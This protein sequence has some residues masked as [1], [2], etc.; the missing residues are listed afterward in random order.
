MAVATGDP[1]APAPAGGAAR[2]GVRCRRVEAGEIAALAD[3]L[4]EGF[5]ARG[6]GAWRDALARLAAWTA[7]QN[8]PGFGYVLAD[9][10]GLVGCLL[11]LYGAGGTRCSLSSW[12]VAQSHRR[13]GTMLVSAALR[14]RTITYL[15]ISSEHHTRP[16]IEAQGF[17]RYTGGVV[18][19][20][21][22]AA[23]RGLRTAVSWARPGPAYAVDP[24][25]AALVA[26]HAGFGCLTFWCLSGGRAHPFVVA[27]RRV[28]N[29]LS[30]GQVVY[31]GPET[32]WRV[33]AHAVGRALA[34]HGLFVLLLDASGPVPGLPGRFLPG[35]MPKYA[36]GPAPPPCGDLAYTEAAL[37]GT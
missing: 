13:F 4:A 18:A 19:A 20:L 29:R 36:R 10:D 26:H 30:I 5:P 31:C 3:L 9:G 33:V 16:I 25:E 32:D 14:D 7:A 23:P 28:R 27:R 21:P 37:L 6:A 8:L 34:R 11:T 35:R 12:Y 24:A 1:V 22:L 15:N 17:R 2:P